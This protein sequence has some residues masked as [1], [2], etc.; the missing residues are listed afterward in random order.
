VE[1]K[2]TTRSNVD[3]KELREGR[4]LK[5]L[6]LKKKKHPRKKEGMCTQVLQAHMQIMKHD[7]LTQVHLFI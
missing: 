7:R 1:K 4:D 6:L 3:P 2:G 5:M